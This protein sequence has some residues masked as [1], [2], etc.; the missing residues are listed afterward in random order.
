MD[1][2]DARVEA[3]ENRERLHRL[4]E[5]LRDPARHI[6]ELQRV[7]AEIEPFVRQGT[8]TE[9]GARET[10]DEARAFLASA[11]RRSD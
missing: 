2:Q 11:P 8:F 7:M 6:D 3:A 1:P 10:V 9:D 5:L 4:R